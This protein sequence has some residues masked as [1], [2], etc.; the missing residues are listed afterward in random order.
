MHK[1]T[2]ALIEP[3]DLNTLVG[4]PGTVILDASFVMPGSPLSPQENFAKSHIPGARIFDIEQVADHNTDLPHM[5]PSTEVF[6][7]EM[8]KLG[9]TN[10]DLVVIYGQSGIVMGPARVWWNFRV[11]GHQN[12]RVLN[13]GLPAWV[14]AGF[15]VESGPQASPAPTQYNARLNPDLVRDIGAM[16]QL[17]EAENVLL[18]DARPA[19]R[20]SGKSPEPRA[21]L[22]SGHIPGSL[23]VPCMQLV[24]PATGKMKAKSELETIFATAGV[25]PGKPL[26]TTCGSGVTACVL[27]LAL[28]ELGY[29]D[30]PVYDGSWSEWGRTESGTDVAQS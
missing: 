7:E 21:G 3:E 30:V 28:Y 22:R 8:S 20:F 13:G 23:N 5:L 1:T 10:N 11:F 12:V 18:L 15:S 14:K 16:K 26:A 6:A 2:S 25:T 24:D 17:S 19:E 9:I 29:K 27:A 4:K